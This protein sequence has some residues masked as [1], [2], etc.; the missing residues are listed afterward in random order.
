MQVDP[1]DLHWQD[2]YKLMTGSIVPRPIA[3]VSTVSAD[4][5]NNLAPFSFFTGICAKPLMVC[6]SP[7]RRGSD[8]AQKDTLV[9]IE[10]TGEFV[11]NVVSERIVLP[12]NEAAAEFA[13]DVDEFRMSGLTPI[14]SVFV[15]P[16]R[17]AESYVHLE[18]KLHQVLSFGEEAGAG[19]LVI[20]E[21]VQIHVDDEMM[22]DGK[23]NMEK[24]QAVGR[25]GGP[26]YTRTQDTFALERKSVPK[27]R[28]TASS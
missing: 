9:N 14:P 27:P 10:Q 21:V 15:K 13:S 16:P 19:S 4:G 25:L 23:I 2:T 11:I 12:M 8:G 20:G 18:C 7:M 6:F 5:V 3:F 22:E 28:D 17:L 1:R 24:L 26:L